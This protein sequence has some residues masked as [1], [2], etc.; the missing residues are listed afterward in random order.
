MLFRRIDNP[1]RIMAYIRDSDKKNMFLVVKELITLTFNK[2]EIP[3]YYF[4]HL[5]K[6]EVTN[7][8]DY[9]GTKERARIHQSKEL[10]SYE[11]S[12][13]MENKLN[14]ANYCE[15]HG[16]NSPTVV[17]YNFLKRFYFQG[18]IQKIATKEELVNYYSNIFRKTNLD[19]LFVKPLAL[20]GGKGCFKISPNN[21]EE[22]MNE[23]FEELLSRSY[24]YTRVV[25]QHGKINEIHSKSVNTLRLL[26]LITENGYTEMIS[27]AM[28][29]GIGENVVD[30][31]SAGGFFIGINLKDGTLKTA[32]WTKSLF[33]GKKITHHPNSNFQ[34][35]GFEV[36]FFKEAC[37]M[38]V[39]YTK[40][41]PNRIIGWD[42]AIE[43]TGPTIIEANHNPYFGLSDI[44]IG[45]LL[46]NKHFRKLV[47]QVN[48]KK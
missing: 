11:L 4:K 45:G 40:Y 47:V 14:F 20:L 16:L 1:E 8:F 5:Y 36:P 37:E 9:L 38:V 21:L 34:L 2:K 15:K 42:V 41:I 26:T 24:I 7:I 22:Q 3:Y 6:K 33:G 43:P 25:K 12:T 44:A 32:G 35:G 18:N 23:H 46:K 28:R 10:Q 30:N 29:F 39:G 27:A 17:G 48:N 13:I 31:N 19:E